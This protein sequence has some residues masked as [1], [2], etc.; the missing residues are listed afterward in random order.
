MIRRPTLMLH[1]IKRV[2]LTH[3]KKVNDLTIEIYEDDSPTPG[4]YIHLFYDGDDERVLI[5]KRHESETP[6]AQDAEV[7]GA[8]SVS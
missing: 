5:D 2:V 4:G 8:G 1:G 3:G 6:T 7:S